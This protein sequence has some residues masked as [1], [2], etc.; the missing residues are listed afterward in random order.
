MDARWR[1]LQ[2]A[3]SA[4]PTGGFAHSAGLEAAVQAREGTCAEELR[5]VL[6]AALWQAGCTALPPV[7]AAHPD[8][9]APPAPARRAAARLPLHALPLATPAPGSAP[10]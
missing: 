9:A 2:L 1:I 10:R 3:D 5:R 7:R 8:P 6:R 4:F